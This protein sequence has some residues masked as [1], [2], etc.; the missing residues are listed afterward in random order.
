MFAVLVVLTN[1]LLF[2][3]LAVF[4][5]MFCM[6]FITAICRLSYCTSLVEVLY[7]GVFL[8]LGVRTSNRTVR[9]VRYIHTDFYP[10]ILMYILLKIR[11]IKSSFSISFYGSFFLLLKLFV[12]KIKIFIFSISVGF[13]LAMRSN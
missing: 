6:N 13:C 10:Q 9:T 3:D 1:N 12:L 5:L 4:N 7:H 2:I 11:L 8:V